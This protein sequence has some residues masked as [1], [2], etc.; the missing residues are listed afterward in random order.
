MHDHMMLIQL[1][2]ERKAVSR[3]ILTHGKH[4]NELSFT[5]RA[6]AGRDYLLYVYSIEQDNKAGGASFQ[7]RTAKVEKTGK[8]SPSKRTPTINP[9]SARRVVL[10]DDHEASYA[11]GETVHLNVRIEGF[12]AFPEF[13]IVWEVDKG[14]GW[15]EMARGTEN[16][17]TFPASSETLNWNYRV[18][19]LF[20]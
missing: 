18:Q 3:E 11:E 7:I 12:D 14:E 9:D 16:F 8:K 10:S 13:L 4:S 5:F 2:E 17:Y 20:S 19:V 15:E 1:R 6:E